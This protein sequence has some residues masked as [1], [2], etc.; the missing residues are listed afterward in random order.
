[1]SCSR[2]IIEVMCIGS[3]AYYYLLKE[4]NKFEPEQ[5]EATSSYHFLAFFISGK[6]I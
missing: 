5:L 3:A 1:M 2:V 4:Q 6:N